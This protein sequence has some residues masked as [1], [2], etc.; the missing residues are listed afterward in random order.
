MRKISDLPIYERPRERLKEHG[1]NNL[2]LEEL[3]A[4]ILKTGTKDLSV[5]DLSYEVIKKIGIEGFKDVTFPELVN[6]RGIGESKALEIISCI[7]FSKRILK[8]VGKINYKSAKDIFS[9]FKDEFS[10]QREMFAVLYMDSMCHLIYKKVLFLGG[11]NKSFIDPKTI[12]H[13]AVKVEATG[14]I[15]IHN[16]PSGNIN[17][18]AADIK[19]TKQIK[20]IG[21]T[22]D[23]IVLDHI[24]FG[25]EYFSFEEN[26]M[27]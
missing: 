7:E 4:I 14:I 9:S 27:I 18:S 22:L 23:I 24:I 12:F 13:Y 20:E 2:S 19:I 6:I 1:A 16:H 15:L 8:T 17:P 25:D 5:L 3:L 10:G 21:N 11:V 26:K